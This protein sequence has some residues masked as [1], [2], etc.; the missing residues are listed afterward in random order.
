MLT[1]SRI[2][3]E[4]IT[5]TAKSKLS[6]FRAITGNA[7]GSSI[8]AVVC[9]NETASGSRASCTR[10]ICSRVSRHN[11]SM[12]MAVWYSIRPACVGV[13]SLFALRTNSGAPTICSNWAIRDDTVD[14]DTFSSSAASVNW[15][16]SY[17]ATRVSSRGNM[18]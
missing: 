13:T 5:C 3:S 14:C 4:F 16:T 18:V 1:R 17:T 2:A 7:F 8:A 9:E 15:P 11:P 12:P 10:A 6:M